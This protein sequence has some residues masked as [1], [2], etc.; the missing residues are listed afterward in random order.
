MI[1]VTHDVDEAVLLGD[2]IIVL[3]PRP[4]RVARIF[5]VTVPRPRSRSSD[6]LVRTRNEI[7][8]TL[9]EG[10]GGSVAQELLSGAGA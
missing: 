8:R 9:G 1:L 7:L 5:D 2:R 3:A 10:D 6:D 4:G